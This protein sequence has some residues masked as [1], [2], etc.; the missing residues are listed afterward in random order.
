MEN[1]VTNIWLKL[2]P[3]AVVELEGHVLHHYDR[4]LNSQKHWGGVLCTYNNKKWTINAKTVDS[5]CS[6]DLQSL[7]VK[8]RPFFLHQTLSS[9]V[10]TTAVCIAP[11]ANAKT[12]LSLL[13]S[14]ISTQLN[15]HPEAVHIIVGDLNHADL[16]AVLPKFHQLV[17]CATCG[18]NLLDKLF[19]NQCSLKFFSALS[20]F[21]CV[22]AAC[23]ST[24]SR[25]HGK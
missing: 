16:K 3:D 17:K 19:L 20:K 5:H 8:C 23:F 7:I 22:W 18:D 21:K 13:H 15:K 9:V 10:L 4:N 6:P 14:T 24:M 12:A 2:I 11:D 25:L 1:I